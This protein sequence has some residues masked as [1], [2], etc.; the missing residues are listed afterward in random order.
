MEEYLHLYVNHHQ[1]DWV[2]WL[3]LCN[4]AANNATSE[5]IQ[6]SPFFT[7][8]GRDFRMNFDHDQP[9]ENP[10]QAYVHEAAAKLRKIYDLVRAEMTAVQ[11]RYSEAYDEARQPAPKFE[12]G[13]QVWLH[14]R[15]IKTTRPARKLD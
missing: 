14:T 5:T 7:T 13:D 8:F 1:D 12:P 2:D 15:H 10:V 6:V 9:I 11:F 4:F 3:P